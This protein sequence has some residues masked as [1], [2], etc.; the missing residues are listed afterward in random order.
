[1]LRKEIRERIKKANSVCDDLLEKGYRTFYDRDTG[2]TMIY[3]K[4]EKIHGVSKVI[5]EIDDNW[6][7]VFY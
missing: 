1:M 6:N 7:P 3:K 4:A 2:K 5:G